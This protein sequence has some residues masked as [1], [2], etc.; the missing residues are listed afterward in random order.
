VHSFVEV[1]KPPLLEPLEPLATGWWQ[2][3]PPVPVEQS[4]L[5]EHAPVLD[6]EEDE[7]EAVMPPVPAI[8]QTPP[9]HVPPGHADPFM[10]MG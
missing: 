1:Q 5:V 3:H 9:W 7:D 10:L 2:Q 8:W 4:W 6:D